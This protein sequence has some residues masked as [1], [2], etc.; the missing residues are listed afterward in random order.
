MFTQQQSATTSYRTVARGAGCRW[1]RTYHASHREPAGP[2][3][4]QRRDSV[5]SCL[6]CALAAP[7]A[8]DPCQQR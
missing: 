6:G 7:T 2:G 5:P 3:N 4:P 8:E 1:A